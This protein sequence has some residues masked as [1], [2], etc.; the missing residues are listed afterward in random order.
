MSSVF[1]SV[2]KGRVISNANLFI[3]A[4]HIWTLLDGDYNHPFLLLDAHIDPVLKL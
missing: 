2:D 4:I 1:D 3:K